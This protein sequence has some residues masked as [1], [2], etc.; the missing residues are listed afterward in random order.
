MI[1]RLATVAG[2]I[3]VVLISGMAAKAQAYDRRS[4]DENS[5]R[6]DVLPLELAKGKSVKFET[7]KLLRL[8]SWAYPMSPGGF[9]NGRLNKLNFISFKDV[10]RS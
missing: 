9:L 1:S 8:L 2:I 3:G 10:D 4:N 6:V 7:R 5:V